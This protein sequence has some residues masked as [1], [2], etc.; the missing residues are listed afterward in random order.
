[1]AR[2]LRRRQNTAACGCLLQ[3]RCKLGAT[4]GDACLE[5]WPRSAPNTS[6]RT[7]AEAGFRLAGTC[8]RT[9]MQD[10]AQVRCRHR[11]ERNEREDSC[12]WVAALRVRYSDRFIRLGHPDRMRH[13]QTVQ[14]DTYV[15]Q[16]EPCRS[17]QHCAEQARV[18]RPQLRHMESESESLG[19]SWLKRR[20]TSR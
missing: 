10:G 6:R 17:S 7:R 16:G 3:L 8:A 18:A 1:M 5:T 4:S 2:R 19:V 20:D 15:A 14:A 11:S 12:S 13:N 9:C